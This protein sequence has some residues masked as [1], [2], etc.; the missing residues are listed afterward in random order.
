MVVDIPKDR[1]QG[2]YLLKAAKTPDGYSAT[3][4]ASGGPRVRA[5]WASVGCGE[6]VGLWEEN[7]Y[8]FYFKFVLGK[9]PPKR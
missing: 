8:D 2:P 1:G 4:S 5:R 3:N 6:F 7:G 9:K